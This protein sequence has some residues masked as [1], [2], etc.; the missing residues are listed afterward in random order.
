MMR[1]RLHYG[2]REYT[3]VDRDAQAVRAQIDRA[4]AGDGEHWLQ[5]TSGEGR[6]TA[7]RLLILPGTEIAV[8]QEVGEPGGGH[9]PLGHDE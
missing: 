5:V 9:E 6:G 8:L 3:I 7:A 4:L 1:V 2:G